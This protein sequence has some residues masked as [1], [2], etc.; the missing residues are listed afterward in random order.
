MTARGP[1]GFNEPDATTPTPEPI[2]HTGKSIENLRA[3]LPGWNDTLLRL[4]LDEWIDTD[5]IGL[6]ISRVERTPEYAAAFPG[7]IRDDGSKRFR[8]EQ[9]YLAA[10]LRFDEELEDLGLRPAPFGDTFVALL[11]DEVGITEMLNRINSVYQRAIDAAPEIR[12]AFAAQN[13]IELTD[14]AIVAAALNP[15]IGEQ[16]LNRQLSIAEITGEGAIRDFNINL[17]LATRLYEV[18]IGRAEAADAFGDAA[19]VV[20]VL[21]VLARR[22][23][24]PNDEFD[25]NDF[26]GATLLD[27]PFERRRMRRLLAR[28][29]ASFTDFA[30][31]AIDREGAVS[32]LSLT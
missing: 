23:N 15:E 9:D 20:P 13:N 24:D 21:N 6:A 11:E 18:G 25:I 10:K 17:G 29:R 3:L 8:T 7:M 22:H 28:E 1:S 4:V 27:D 2:D 14:A 30:P 32:G 31:F 16:I 5:D 26:V 19:S 12:A